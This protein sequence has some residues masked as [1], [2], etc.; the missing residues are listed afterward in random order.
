MAG[1]LVAAN[2]VGLPSIHAHSSVLTYMDVASLSPLPMGVLA[3]N[4]PAPVHTVIVK[5]TFVTT[6]QSKVALADVQL[7]LTTDLPL[8]DGEEELYRP[9]D[10]VPRKSGVDVVLVGHARSRAPVRTIACGMEVGSWRVRLRAMA[11][12]PVTEI[13]LLARFLR[14]AQ[15]NARRPVRLAAARTKVAGWQWRTVGADFDFTAFNAAS[16]ALRIAELAPDA[17]LVLDNLLPGASRQELQLAGVT[18]FVFHVPD[19]PEDELPPGR[20]VAMR[21][22]SLW[23]DTDRGLLTLTWR[24]EVARAP[25]DSARPLLVAAVGLYASPPS[26]PALAAKLECAVWHRGVEE[27]ALVELE[28]WE[29]E[30]TAL[31][32][33]EEGGWSSEA[34]PASTAASSTAPAVDGAPTRAPLPWPAGPPS[35]QVSCPERGLASS[36]WGDEDTTTLDEAM[37]ALSSSKPQEATADADAPSTHRHDAAADERLDDADGSELREETLRLPDQ[38][39]QAADPLPFAR[40][41]RAS[42]AAPARLARGSG[43]P[44]GVGH[45]PE[46]AEPAAEG[47]GGGGS[48]TL[49]AKDAQAAA[50]AALPFVRDAA[51]GRPAPACPDGTGPSPSQRAQVSTPLPI[52]RASV[53]RVPD[54]QRPWTPCRAATEA[55]PKPPSADRASHRRK[56][57]LET[58][59][60][61]KVDLH[62]GRPLAEALAEHGVEEAAWHEYEREQMAAIAEDASKGSVERATEVRQAIMAARQAPV[63]AGAGEAESALGLERF[64]ELQVA[65]ED[66]E[67]SAAMLA[68]HGLG[69]AEWERQQRHWMHRA[70]ADRKIATRLRRLLATARQAALQNDGEECDSQ[71][72]ND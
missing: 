38:P 23:L 39:L 49:A 68:R 65:L 48:G 21:C 45:C 41:R 4:G 71:A 31:L 8:P 59:A 6:Q 66:A 46:T 22:D 17:R 34:E 55:S 20:P 15:G 7:P 53:S 63:D 51:R 11:P 3:W 44:A 57:S 56:L 29:P 13:P 9:S 16:P 26:W 1:G 25:Y 58:Y 24:G 37:S 10:Y 14:Q 60:A 36:A 69:P 67:D 2:A 64:A 70:K 28:P 18:P 5:A 12:E 19:R 52:D 32:A 42:T 43:V 54:L 30:R 33:P 47:V 72:P 27:D 61:I 35:E 40:A 62:D 50:A